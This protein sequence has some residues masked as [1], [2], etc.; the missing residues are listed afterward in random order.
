MRG[1]D[2]FIWVHGPKVGVESER[3]VRKSEPA[4]DIK[5]VDTLPVRWAFAATYDGADNNRTSLHIALVRALTN[6]QS[7][8]DR[9]SAFV[10]QIDGARRTFGVRLAENIELPRD[11]LGEELIGRFEDTVRV[12]IRLDNTG[13]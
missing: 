4:F 6:T 7:S 11:T 2:F 10:D 1:Y 3:G 9:K 5:R 12:W 13:C 8:G